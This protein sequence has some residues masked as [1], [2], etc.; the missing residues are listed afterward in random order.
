MNLRKNSSIIE[1]LRFFLIGQWIILSVTL[2]YLSHQSN[3]AFLPK[4]VLQ[5][6]KLLHFIAYFIYGLSTFTMLLVVRKTDKKLII[7]GFVVSIL[8]AISDEIHQFFVPDRMMDIY[9]LV[10]DL[11]GIL[12]SVLF[13]NLI[14]KNKLLHVLNFGQRQDRI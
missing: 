8:F 3:I 2:F 10:A 4:D 13:F 1:K 5:Y 11:L 6:D 7:I 12:F 14:L 9:D